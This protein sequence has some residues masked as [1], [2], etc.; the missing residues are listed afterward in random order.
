VQPQ[1]RF[2]RL[3]VEI[4]EEFAAEMPSPRTQFFHDASRS[5]ISRNDSP[6]IPFGASINPY[7][8]CEHGCAYC[9]ARP[10]HEYLGFSSGLDFESRILVKTEAPRLLREELM[11][12]KWQPQVLA[13]SGVTDC[14]QPVE[15]RLEIT[16]RCLE[17][18]A[19]FR[20]PVGIVTK[21]HLVTRD[22]DHLAS[23]AAH[24][25]ARVFLSITTLGADLSSKLEPR[26]SRPTHRLDAVRRL[27]EAGV[28]AGVMVAPILPGLNEHEI[29][30]ILAAAAEAGAVSAGYTV[31]RL[32]HAVKD[33]FTAWLQT[34]F[35]ERAAMVLDRVRSLRRGRLNVS[36]F[37]ER[38]RGEGIFA[39]EIA[40]LFEVS[41]RRL[42]LN[43]ERPPLSTAAFR[44]PG[45]QQMTLF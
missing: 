26:A 4:D 39:D 11:N 21:N 35:P 32:P 43:R 10:Y 44:R 13:M 38:F 42:G 28:P 9:Y 36:D 19:E 7:R 31:L 34:H 40:Q 25:A 27:V 22:I 1:N 24:G 41:A 15:R 12:P 8:G 6:D 33:V 37:G 3:A 16:R 29:P 14:Y 23:L 45:P 30:A 20:N 17:V 2:E 5:I 18:L